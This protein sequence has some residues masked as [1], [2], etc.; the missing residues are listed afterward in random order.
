MHPCPHCGKST[1]GT[2]TNDGV[3]H[4][5][6]ERCTREALKADGIS[7]PAATHETLPEARRKIAGKRKGVRG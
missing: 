2:D 4:A 7:V 5:T 1:S 6:C 3:V